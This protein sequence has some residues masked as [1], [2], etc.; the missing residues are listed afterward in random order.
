MSTMISDVLKS[1]GLSEH[2]SSIAAAIEEGLAQLDDALSIEPGQ[3]LDTR[4]RSLLEAAGLDFAPTTG[5]ELEAIRLGAA[6]QFANLTASALTVSE[7]AEILD[8]DES[9]I[10]Q[11]LGDHTLHGFKAGR[12]WQI[13]SWQ[14]EH[15]AELPGL[16]EV[17]ASSAEH[18]PA[19]LCSFMTQPSEELL[20][21]G[22]PTAPRD[23][24]LA[25]WPVDRVAKL[26]ASLTRS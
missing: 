15:S 4:E 16:A 20:A 25:G 6:E 23:W 5:T 14:F 17:M 10:R 13:P 19:A 21:D 26:A 9:R 12:A 2:E 1:A 24:L 18:H 22:I 11:R 7:A 3:G 8:V